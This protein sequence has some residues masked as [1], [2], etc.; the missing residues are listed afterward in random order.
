MR[1]GRP[2]RSTASDGARQ[3]ERGRRRQGGQALLEMALALPAFLVAFIAVF[4]LG[5][6]V[7]SYNSLTNAAREGARLA[8]VNQDKPSIIQRAEEQLSVGEIN[9]PNVT[10]NFYQQATSGAN[11]G[12]PDTSRPCSPV[13]VNCL[14]VV[15]FETTYHPFTPVIAQILFPSGVTFTA[16]SILS[17][18]YSCPNATETAAQCPRQP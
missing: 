7:F 12:G 17:V 4:D 16:Q 1:P 3:Q 11:I 9:A 5:S 6:A 18:E 10:V 2:R 14:A 13:A 8:I 15:T